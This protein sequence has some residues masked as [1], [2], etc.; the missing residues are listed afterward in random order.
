MSGYLYVMHQKHNFSK[1]YTFNSIL[2][3]LK[4]W[5][6]A[7]FFPSISFFKAIFFH[8]EKCYVIK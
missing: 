3:T 1:K 6:K 8:G 5:K 2:I 7:H 4:T